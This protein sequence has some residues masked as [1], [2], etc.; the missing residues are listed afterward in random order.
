MPTTTAIASRDPAAKTPARVFDMIKSRDLI[1]VASF[2][3]LGLLLTLGFAAVFPFA[4]EWVA[5]LAAIS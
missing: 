1:A 2:V 5:A 4:N 3:V